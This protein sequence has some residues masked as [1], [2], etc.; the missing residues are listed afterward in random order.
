M[1]KL[2]KLIAAR[3]AASIAVALLGAAGLAASG[4]SAS[5]VT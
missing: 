3:P 2:T 1:M 4:G 5:Q